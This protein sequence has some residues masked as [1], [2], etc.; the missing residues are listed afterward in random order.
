MN[1]IDKQL[2]TIIRNVACE[3]ALPFD[4]SI[5][6]PELLFDLAKKHDVAHFVGYLISKGDIA[7]STD[8]TRKAFLQ[9]YYQAAFRVTVLE[10]ELKSIIR[11][12]EDTCID[13][14]PLK[15]AVLRKIYPAA[16]MRVSADIDIL[17]HQDDL[18]KAEKVLFD[19]LNYCVA[20]RGSHDDQLTTP[21]GFTVELHFTLTESE[22]K[23]SPILD[24]VWS[25]CSAL[26]ETAHE[27]QM[28]D[29]LLYLYHIFHTAKHFL[30]GGCGIRSVLDTWFLNHKVNFDREKR[31]ALL[32]QAG[33]ISFATALEEVS[34]AWFSKKNNSGLS[35]I[36][37]Y[38]L[39]GGVYGDAQRVAAGQARS[40]NRLH[41]FLKR[42]FPSLN[43]MKNSYRVLERLQVLLPF[44]WVHRLICSL[45]NGKGKLAYYEYHKTKEES[46]RSTE[47]MNLFQKL[48]IR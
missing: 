46:E 12:F 16:W 47:I 2:I 5:N 21:S 20:K 31:K 44:C 39:Y 18:K 40:N 48:E 35:E 13:F 4:F 17:V 22:S 15:G 14:I 42:A 38:I 3:S 36:E 11:V 1:Q 37:E 33:L 8:E 9:Q 32:Q 24:N 27:L 26:E 10:T 7:I 43:S 23:A 30:L 45:F 28:N 25:K 34:E 19:R 6:T 29:D 41:Y